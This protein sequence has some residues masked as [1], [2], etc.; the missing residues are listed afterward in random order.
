MSEQSEKKDYFKKQLMNKILKYILLTAG[1]VLCLG[2]AVFAAKN[3]ISISKEHVCSK[4]NVNITDFNNR[5]LIT[6]TEIARLLESEGLNPIGKTLKRIKTKS[7]E[8]AI[9]KHPMVRQAEC[10]K[11]PEGEITVSIDQRIPVLRVVGYENY[12]VDDMR[13][14]MPISQNFAAYVPV[15]SGRVTKKMATGI[16]FE[17]AEYINNDPF[18]SNQIIQININDKLKVELVPRVGDHMVMMGDLSRYKQKLEKLKKLY[19]YGLNEIG[20][21]QYKTIDLQFRDQVVC[22]KK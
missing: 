1:I 22:T 2:Y 15:I 20:W 17:F 18:W 4:I 19:L 9:E 13:K 12:Y 16:L 6:N 10:Y 11:T 3:G 14:P 5:Q 21:N 7:I 8:D